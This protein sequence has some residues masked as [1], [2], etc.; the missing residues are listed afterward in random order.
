[1]TLLYE[2]I[3]AALPEEDIGNHE[4]DLYPKATPEALAI[5][6]EQEIHGVSFFKHTVTHE[7]WVE[8]PFAYDPWWEAKAKK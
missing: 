8:V 3:K 5:L 4:S 1:M 2:A 6:A 7:T